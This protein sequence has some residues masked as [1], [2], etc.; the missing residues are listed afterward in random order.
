M[1]VV[2][3]VQKRANVMDITELVTST[4]D[5]S[6]ISEVIMNDVYYSDYG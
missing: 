2:F 6:K 3:S 4:D 5:R 1:G